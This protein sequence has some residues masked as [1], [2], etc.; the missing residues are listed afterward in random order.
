[1]TI[2][3]KKKCIYAYLKC[4]WENIKLCTSGNYVHP[5]QISCCQDVISAHCG[6]CSIKPSTHCL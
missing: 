6:K 3:E 4:I 1:M 2:R 5:L